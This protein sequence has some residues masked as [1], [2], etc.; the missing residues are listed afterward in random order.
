[1]FTRISG[2]HG[3]ITHYFPNAEMSRKLSPQELFLC[4]SGAQYADGTTDVST[5]R[6]GGG[7][8]GG[9]GG[10]IGGGGLCVRDI[11]VCV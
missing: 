2:P 10:G 11:I 3:A 5:W 7:G 8:G 6:K 9:G 4:D 1:M